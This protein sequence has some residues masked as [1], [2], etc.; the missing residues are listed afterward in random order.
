MAEIFNFRNESEDEC[1]C[2]A[3]ATTADYLHIALEC[4]SEQELSDCLRG[5]YEDAFDQGSKEMLRQD[6]AVKLDLLQ[7]DGDLH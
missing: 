2:D 4:E 7:E 6:V 1:Q 5:L 3:C